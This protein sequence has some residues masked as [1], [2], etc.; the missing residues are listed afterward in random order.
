M[1][2]MKT[3]LILQNND[4]TG[5]Y[6][7]AYAERAVVIDLGYVPPLHSVPLRLPRNVLATLTPH[8]PSHTTPR[9]G[10]GRCVRSSVP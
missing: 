4:F 5:T 9:T 7:R 6:V 3:N 8:L 2:Q 10:Q 1:T